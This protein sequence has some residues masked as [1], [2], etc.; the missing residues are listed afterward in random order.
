MLRKLILA[1]ATIA[2]ATAVVVTLSAQEKP[3]EERDDQRFEVKVTDEMI[4]HSRI[5]NTLYFAGFAYSLGVLALI[6]F[7]GASRRMRDLAARVT[8]KKYLMAMLYIVLFT[9]AVTLLEFPLTYYSGY[10]VPHRFD[11]TDQTFG[12]WITDQAKGLGVGLVLGTLVGATA[13]LIIRK[14]SWWWFAL[15]LVSIPFLITIIVIQPIVLDPI[16]NKFEPLRDQTLKRDLLDLASR[17]GIEGGR[18]Y[19]VNKSKQTKTMNAY[20]NGIGPTARIVMWDTLLAKMTHDEVLAVM[21]HE[22]GHYAMKHIWKGLAFSLAL[23]FGVFFVGQRVHDRGLASR[24]A[25]WGFTERGD[26]ASVPWLLM[27]VSVISFFLSPIGSGYSRMIEHDADI[28]SLELTHL[29][30]PMATAFIKF[31]EDSKRNPT[32]HPFIKYWLYSHP[33][34]GE[35]IEFALSYKPWE[36]GEPNRLWTGGKKEPLLH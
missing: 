19:Q 5:R 24:G 18:V 3:K 34:L 6:L 15:W 31:A 26:P 1:A 4:R 27:I 29:N 21:G 8:N 23:A 12:G 33:P 25:R 2:V 36:Q 11:L 30:E 10:V 28:F 9:L 22:M 17:A 20:V 35:R 14:L 16:F 32:P 7:S 13:L